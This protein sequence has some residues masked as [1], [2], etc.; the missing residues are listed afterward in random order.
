MGKAPEFPIP[1]RRGFKCVIISNC[2]LAFCKSLSY[3]C[4]PYSNL[5]YVKTGRNKPDEEV[6]SLLPTSARHGA[7]NASSL[8]HSNLALIMSELVKD[9]SGPSRSD[10][11]TRTGLTLPTV[12]RLVG[13]LIDAGIVEEGPSSADGSLGRPGKQ[14]HPVSKAVVGIGTEV[15]VDHVAGCAIDLLGNVVARFNELIDGGT[16]PP[17]AILERLG[18]ALKAMIKNLRSRGFRSIC[19]ITLAAPS[20]IDY[21]KKQVIYASNLEWRN[22]NPQEYLREYIPEEVP[23][24]VD[25]DANLEALASASALSGKDPDFDS[26]L[27]VFGEFGIG[28]ALIEKGR[29]VRGDH[30]WCGEIG[31][32]T[33]DPFGEK[34]YCGAIGCLETLIGRRALMTKAGLSIEASTEDLVST[35]E[36]GNIDALSAVKK[37]GWALGL[38]LANAANLIDINRIVLGN[39]LAPL[40]PWMSEE[41]TSQLD[42]HLIGRTAETIKV[43][44]VQTDANSSSAGGALQ[45]LQVRIE[46]PI[47]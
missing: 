33:V 43:R 12:S 22:I 42:T 8:R 10:L 27:Y 30:G 29:V 31:H 9:Q 35:L 28:G 4:V 5:S 13:E 23:F 18:I 6:I 32:M 45:S 1:M 36:A 38:A 14:L 39:G 16:L 21:E 3:Y 26:F 24:V 15:N 47:P 17:T 37:G 20:P 19:G 25:N 44:G 7:A 46:T 34:C 40:L 11:A 41:I 2:Y